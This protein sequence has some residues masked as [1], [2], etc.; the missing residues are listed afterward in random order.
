MEEMEQGKKYSAESKGYNDKIYEI[1]WIPVM[2]RPEYQEGPVR[3]ALERLKKNMTE[4]DF[5]KY[6]DNGLIRVTYDGSHLLLI[7]KSEIYRTMLYGPFSPIICKA[8]DVGNFRV[9]SQVNG[10]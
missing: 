1:R 3:E 7:A 8:F 4:K 9:V 5:D 2:E 10:Y 6:I